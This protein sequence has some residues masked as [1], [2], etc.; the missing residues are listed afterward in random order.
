[1][2]SE[3]TLIYSPKVAAKSATDNNL[4]SRKCELNFLYI[5]LH[6]D[7]TWYLS[8]FCKSGTYA[9]NFEEAKIFIKDA[10]LNNK[11]PDFIIIDLPYHQMQLHA[12][13]GFLIINNVFNHIA[14][15]YSDRHLNAAQINTVKDIL[16]IDDVLN[17]NDWSVNYAAKLSFLVKFKHQEVS[18]AHNSNSKLLKTTS[19]TSGA[20]FAKRC[21]DIAV[22]SILLVLSS[23]LFLII[24]LAIKIESKGPV[25]Y[26]SLRAGRY[27]NI[28]RFFKFRTMHV[29]ADKKVNEL[30]HMNQYETDGNGPMFLKIC[31]DPRVTKVGKL[32]R[33]TSLDELPQLINVLIG[34]MSIVG[35]RPLPLYEAST[36][37]TDTAVERF[38]APAGI[39][40]LWQVKK[41]SC[42]DMSVEERIN[43]DIT[44]ARTF[45]LFM[46]MS[47]ILQTPGALFQK[48]NV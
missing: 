8:S 18:L 14:I 4:L 23:P 20:L 27:F 22:A 43:L 33:N 9:E 48:A 3:A 36:L 1:M 28:F 12:F 31:N 17:I 32:L 13:Y 39:T 41:R 11:L 42:K 19:H 40:G 26:T 30:L 29:D 10:L 46:D 25:F 35:N 7:T 24:A 2:Y 37:T 5:G 21:F 16:F 6:K 47:I 38:T 34:N 15:I 44:Y 45:N